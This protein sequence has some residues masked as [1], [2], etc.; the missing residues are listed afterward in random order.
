MLLFSRVKAA[1]QEKALLYLP[2]AWCSRIYASSQYS[3]GQ[4]FYMQWRHP[5]ATLLVH[6]YSLLS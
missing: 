6:D 1:V 5:A 4:P 3:S 2:V